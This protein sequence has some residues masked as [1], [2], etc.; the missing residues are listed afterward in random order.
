MLHAIIVIGDS[1]TQR[2]TYFD[3]EL[4][5]CRV[6]PADVI[7]LE[8]TDEK[9]FIGISQVRDFTRQMILSPLASEKKVGL[10]VNAQQLTTEAQNALL[11]IIEEPPKNVLFMLGSPSP[12][13]L[14][15]TVVS[16]CQI[17]HCADVPLPSSDDPLAP[18]EQIESLVTSTPSVILS[19]IQSIASDRSATKLWTIA[20][21]HTTRDLMLAELQGNKNPRR[22]DLLGKTIRALEQARKELSA[23][24]TP[25]LVLEHAFLSR[26]K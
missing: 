19:T 2:S 13:A 3:Q 8:L 15:P 23:N 6:H 10:I 9:E 7:R 14:L 16:R 25:R 24:V 18:P 12:D 11:K 4:A 22:L 20:A 21:I 26:V 1:E 17:V 5:K